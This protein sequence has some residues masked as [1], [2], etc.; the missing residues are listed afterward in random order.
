M[1]GG[2][3]IQIAEIEP[4]VAELWCVDRYGTETAVRV[5]TAPE[6]PESG[7]EVWWQAGKVHWDNDRRALTKIAN[8]YAKD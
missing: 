8:S 6:M 1:V 7:D 5:K 4:G 2:W 3:V